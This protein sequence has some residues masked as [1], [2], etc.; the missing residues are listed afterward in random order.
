MKM[1]KLFVFAV[2]L[3][4]LTGCIS[5]NKE[6]AKEKVIVVPEKSSTDY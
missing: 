4:G 2:A 6:P 1:L 3:T 5:I